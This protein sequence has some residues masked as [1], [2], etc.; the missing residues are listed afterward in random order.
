MKFLFDDGDQDVSRHGAPYLGLHRVLTGGQ[1]SLDAQMLL[2]PLEQ[3][4]DILPIGN[5]IRKL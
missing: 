4:G 3:L 1:K 2:D 5:R